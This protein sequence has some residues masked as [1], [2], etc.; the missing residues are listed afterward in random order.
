MIKLDFNLAFQFAI[1]RM[2]D[3]NIKYAEII[4]N[5]KNSNVDRPFTYMVD[6]DLSSSLKIGMRVIVPFGLGNKLIKGVVINILDDFHG[7]YKLKSVIDI[8]DDKALISEDLIELSMWMKDEYLSSYIDCFRQIFP[9]GD[10]RKINTFIHL[11]DKYSAEEIT[12]EEGKILQHLHPKKTVL[13]EDLKSHFKGYN[14]NAIL[15]SMED[16]EIISTYIDINSKVEKKYEKQVK[17]VNE[18]LT[19]EKIK[20]KIGNRAKKQI[21]IAEFLYDIGETSFKDLSS[22]LNTSLNTVR[23][24]EKKGIIEIYEKEVNRDPIKV[25]IPKYE[26]HKLSS[27]QMSV[28]EEIYNNFRTNEQN[29]FLIRGVTGSGKTEIYLQLVEAMIEKGKESIVLVPEISLTP[30]TIDRFVGR[31]GDLVAVIHSKLSYGERFD[32]W[33]RIKNG[34]VKIVVG[35]RSAV[36]APF[37]NL[38]LIVIDEEHESTYKSSQ[39]PKYDTIE[40]A[41]KRVDIEDAFL[42]L[43][44][45]TPSL[46]SYYKALRGDIKLLELEERV[47]NYM[48]PKVSVIDMREE[49]KDGNKSI[50][51]RE[52]H[53]G[54][55]ENLKQNKQT[56]LFLNRRGFSTFVSCRQCGYVVKCDN[57]DISMTYHRNIDRLRC[58]YCG[59]AI[60][61]PKICPVCKSNYIKYFG[62]GTE[63]VEEYTKKMFPGALVARMDFDT[64]S[65]KG[66]YDKILGSMKRGEIDILIGTQMIS[67]G[68]DFKDVT[69][70]GVIAADTSLNLPDFRAPERTFQL[71]TQVAGRAGRGADSG[72]VVVQTYDPNH[73][74]IVFSKEHDYKSFY[75]NEIGLRKSFMYPPFYSMINILL[76]GEDEKKVRSLA[77]NVQK[78]I[79]K[80]AR[81]LDEKDKK[82]YIIGPNPAPLEK[83]KNNYRWHIILKTEKQNIGTFKSILKRV[84]IYNEYKLKIED[85]R[86]S[87]DINPNSIL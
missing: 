8:I 72:R 46:E 79:W 36:F 56:I 61:S 35:A 81:E 41:S 58:H 75:E 62:V 85:V 9:P 55:S 1:Q 45:A 37:N 11:K 18:K 19:I 44:S 43:G 66:S 32:E 24:L 5:N 26:K 29:K 30:Q 14:L 21:Q 57:C 10:F 80:E 34:Q 49:L 71:I 78:L 50:F 63:Q 65:K 59:L 42:V 3:L 86:I 6:G 17:L 33:R 27:K 16:K 40:L 77:Y 20:E 60:P 13:L 52:L 23:A 74:S 69:L 47:N 12:E 15:N 73:Y 22:H 25:N 7:N 28:Y 31:F 4:I 87:I 48:L 2:N 76:Y 51:S 68:L 84:L 64:T 39:N 70:V 53:E 54:I 82:D 38:G 83:I 67:K